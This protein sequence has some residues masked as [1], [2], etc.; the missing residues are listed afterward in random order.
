M[1]KSK[2][3]G[4]EID[5]KLTKIDDVESKTQTNTN[6]ITDLTTKTN[7]LENQV[8]E[9]QTQIT[10]L[11][12]NKIEKTDGVITSNLISNDSIIT[13]KIPD[14]T[15]T[16]AKIANHQVT[17]D[18]LTITTLNKINNALQTPTTAPTST[19]L[20]GI[21]T[22]KAQVN[23]GIGNGLSLE[24]GTLKATGGGTEVVA[25]P[26]LTGSESNLTGL[27]VAGTK[28]KVPTGGSG[29][30]VFVYLVE[31]NNKPED[32]EKYNCVF[33]ILHNNEN[34]TW[35][36]II[37]KCNDLIIPASGYVVPDLSNSYNVTYVQINTDYCI[38]L[39]NDGTTTLQSI[40]VR[41]DSGRIDL[42]K[43]YEV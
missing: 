43:Y 8:T 13:S 30:G 22:N 40:D 24:N 37:L 27:E 23:I 6:N 14:N 35:D 36:D 21:N 4:Q 34:L 28:Y 29:S 17:D 25:N 15:I 42:S 32:A 5:D 33:Q 11:Q 19:E 41:Y 38:I 39:Y 3:T 31:I 12:N 26:T 18:K 20:V 2:F 1:Y 16:S 9:Q 10:D 7:D